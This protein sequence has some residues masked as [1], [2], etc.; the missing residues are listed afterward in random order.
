MSEIIYKIE[1]FSDWHC[2]SGLGAGA[3]ADALVIKDVDGLPFVPGKTLKGVIKESADILAEVGAFGADWVEDFFGKAAIE[4]SKKGNNNKENPVPSQT[5]RAVFSNAELSGAVKAELQAASTMKN[6]QAEQ[7]TINAGL[8]YRRRSQTAIDAEGLAVEN[9]LR[10]MEV[11]VPL[12]LFAKISRVNDTDTANLLQC[13]QAIR[14]MGVGRNRG[15]GRC[16]F[17]FYKEAKA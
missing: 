6:G 1:F 14:Q 12:T 10:T 4:A 7:S 13:L 11:T 17:S 2:G 8:F 3:D 15:L 9:S 5:G 16:Q